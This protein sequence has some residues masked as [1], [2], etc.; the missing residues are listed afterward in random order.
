[1]ATGS[2]KAGVSFYQNFA[3][4]V[5][6]V[7][8]IPSEHAWITDDFGNSCSTLGTPYINNCQYDAAG[9]ML[10]WFNKN[11][12]AKGAYNSSNLLQYVQ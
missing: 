9:Q 2:V 6:F 12:K 4:N 3:A 8:N 5:Q 10:T 7:N 1:M 11:T